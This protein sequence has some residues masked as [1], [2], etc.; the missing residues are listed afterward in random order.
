MPTAS[1]PGPGRQVKL[2]ALVLA[3]VLLP[4]AVLALLEGVSSAVLLAIALGQGRQH[5]VLRA[6]LHTR[7]DPQLGWAAVPNF[8]APDM[9]GPNVPVRIGARGFRATAPEGPPP[10]GGGT[11]VVCS[12][13]SFTFGLGVADGR[14]W[15][16]LLA[17]MDPRLASTNMGQS[18]YGLDQVYL[19]YKRDGQELEHDIQLLA[20]ITNDF[21]RMQSNAAFGYTKPVVTVRD[22]SLVTDGVPVPASEGRARRY[23]SAVLV[24]N[25][26]RLARMATWI[27]DS[28]F[29]GHGMQQGSLSGVWTA[30]DS[31]TWHAVRL[32][33]RD[34]A[35]INRAKSSRLV[36]VHLPVFEDYWTP[37]ADAWR[38]RAREAARPGEFEFID[39]VQE[40]RR[41]PADS[42]G[43]LF[44]G[45]QVPGSADAQGHYSVSGNEWVAR[46]ILRRLGEIPPLATTLGA[47]TTST[48]RS[49]A[50]ARN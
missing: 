29:H 22:D 43:Q 45:P 49:A 19:W 39:L 46:E 23:W 2:L 30:D 6:R 27:R 47:A 16:A 4:A 35:E 5:D 28:V 17:T 34:L 10:D 14:T 1:S 42:A 32:M 24:R 44:I 18:G 21:I 13:D 41:L 15:C 40:F 50:A 37:Q 12:G 38:V 3:T 26:L 33:V 48:G 36:L 25:E 9:Y 11:R 8:A 31:L 20:Y 7:H